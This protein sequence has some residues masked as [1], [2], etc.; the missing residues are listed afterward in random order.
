MTASHTPPPDAG[1]AAIDGMLPGLLFEWEDGPAFRGFRWVGSAAHEVCGVDRDRLCAGWDALP[2]HDDDRE[3]FAACLDQAVR[4]GAE[5]SH[6]ARFLTADGTSRWWRANARRVGDA[7]GQVRFV[8]QLF[9]IDA[10]VRRAEEHSRETERLRREIARSEE[11]FDLAI[12]ASN[13]GVF[14][15]EIAHGD[16]YYSPA[17]GRLLGGTMATL[18]R[19]LRGWRRRLDQ[20]AGRDLVQTLLAHIRSRASRFG[21]VVTVVHANGGRVS[22]EVNAR[23]LYDRNGR[24]RRVVGLVA[25]VTARV[26][27]ERGLIAAMDEAEAAN[28]AKSEF[29]ARMSHELRTPLNSIIGF[30]RL[31]GRRVEGRLTAAEQ[32]QIA[33]IARNGHNLLDLINDILDLSKIE[34]GRM[35]LHPE[36]VDLGELMRQTAAELEGSIGNRPVVLRTVCPPGPTMHVVDPG[37][38]RQVLVNLIGNALKFTV[39]GEV[40]VTLERR[41]DG[42]AAWIDVMD[43][44]IGIAEE[45]REKIFSPFEQA[46]ESTAR[47][48]G[49]TGL[50]L[51]IVRKLVRMMGG[52]IS[53]AS[54]V[55]VG[56]VFRVQ[57]APDA[58]DRVTA[59]PTRR[60]A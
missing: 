10:D 18:P 33:R 48:F 8:G 56:S 9:D 2:L 43:T 12:G 46:E 42:S 39:E 53:L 1:L 45:Q 29:L 11:R 41:P 30:A 15:W 26:E 17:V 20:R 6:R 36:S 27:A 24:A 38:L 59:L 21:T 54:E 47:R 16:I 37:K 3:G 5:W 28:R 13:E 31:L 58:D 51:A 19:T 34:A 52:D 22:A 49:G 60:A 40:R 14:D 25:D 23:I 7:G 32:D 4:D 35:E 44:G 50:G 57:L 55:G